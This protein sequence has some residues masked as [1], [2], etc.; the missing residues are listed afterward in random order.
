MQT[1][2]CS[3]AGEQQFDAADYRSGVQPR[4][5]TTRRGLIGNFGAVGTAI[6]ETLTG[7]TF[8]NFE[9]TTVTV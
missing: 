4:S 8:T 1:A 7:F 6:A 9:G 2:I 3:K 5:G